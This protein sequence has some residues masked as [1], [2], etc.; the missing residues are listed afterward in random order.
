MVGN[1]TIPQAWSFGR[2]A[3][4][5]VHSRIACDGARHAMLRAGSPLPTQ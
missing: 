5:S 1:S 3:D 2:M 4:L